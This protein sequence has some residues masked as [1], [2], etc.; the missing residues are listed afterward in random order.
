MIFKGKLKETLILNETNW[1]ITENKHI[2]QKPFENDTIKIPTFEIEFI[3]NKTR[4][5]KQPIYFK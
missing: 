3:L 5:K 1:N 4:Q 2:G